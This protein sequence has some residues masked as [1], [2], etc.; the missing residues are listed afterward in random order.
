MFRACSFAY[1]YEMQG[2]S[3]EVGAFLPDL[4]LLRQRVSLRKGPP[5]TLSM[6]ASVSASPSKLGKS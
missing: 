4:F 5:P 2:Y 6:N 1:E 3:L